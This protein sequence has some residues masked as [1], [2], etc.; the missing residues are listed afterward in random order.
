ML[1]ENE[2]RLIVRVSWLMA[3]GWVL[4]C[5]SACSGNDVGP[6]Q[7][8]SPTVDATSHRPHE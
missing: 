4:C 6:E 5:V 2:L 7:P 8:W 1:L 3:L